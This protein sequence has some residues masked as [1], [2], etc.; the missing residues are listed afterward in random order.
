MR[1]AISGAERSAER[2]GQ[3]L[4]MKYGERGDTPGRREPERQPEKAELEDKHR[5][6][7]VAKENTKEPAAFAQGD[8]GRDEP[9]RHRQIRGGRRVQLERAHKIDHRQRVL[10]IWVRSQPLEH[11]CV[12]QERVPGA[13]AA[14]KP[15]VPKAHR[16]DGDQEDDGAPRRHARR[17]E[18]EHLESVLARIFARRSLGELVELDARPYQKDVIA[19]DGRGRRKHHPQRARAAAQPQGIGDPH[20]HEHRRE[21][22]RGVHAIASRAVAAAEAPPAVRNDS[23]MRQAATRNSGSPRTRSTASRSESPD[24]RP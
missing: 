10:W 19:R 17:H 8:A 23:R 16:V 13:V 9:G 1:P 15:I 22:R 7:G 4:K 18:V 24:R 5:N 6:D 14:R 20:R 21:D 11:R 3:H 2:D 12:D